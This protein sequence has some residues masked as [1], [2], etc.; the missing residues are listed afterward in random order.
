MSEN[1]EGILEEVW[2][3]GVL[4]IS[5]QDFFR[6]EKGYFVFDFWGKG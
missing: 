4:C 6:K 1:E 5:G 3:Y 2:G